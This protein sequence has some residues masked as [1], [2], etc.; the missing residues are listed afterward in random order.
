M[1]IAATS[2]CA[3]CV[4][5]LWAV[6][7]APRRPIILLSWCCCC[8]HCRSSPLT[9]FVPRCHRPIILVVALLL[10][11]LVPFYLEVPPPAPGWRACPRA[12]HS[13]RSSPAVPPAHL[14]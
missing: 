12:A 9:A 7:C 13:S 3:C 8:G 14:S 1:N 10:G 6:A 11:L 4:C 2:C 5:C